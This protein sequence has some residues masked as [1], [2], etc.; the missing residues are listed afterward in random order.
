MAGLLALTL[1]PTMVLAWL[2]Y[3][4][5]VR[6]EQD[7][8]VNH[9]ATIALARD[10]LSAEL[11]ALDSRIPRALPAEV[12]ST[13]LPAIQGWLSGVAAANPWTSDL[14]FV[15]DSNAIVTR[16]LRYGWQSAGVDDAAPSQAIRFAEEAEFVTRDL[17]MA[18]ERYRTAYSAASDDAAKCLAQARIGRTLFKLGRLA[19]AVA[20]YRQLHAIAG[21]T[22]S[23]RGV[24]YAIIALEE[25]VDGLDRGSTVQERRRTVLELVTTIINAPWDGSAGYAYHLKRAIA[26]TPSLDEPL[27]SQALTRLGEARAIEALAVTG[28]AENRGVRYRV[29]SEFVEK[30][31]LPTDTTAVAVNPDV[32]VV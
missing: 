10:K 20:A 30:H 13:D 26:L 1:V 16:A 14:H 23:P 22:R 28:A 6:R 3:R 19:E 8:R 25:I 17:P 4:D 18:V 24:P 31:L 12:A 15:S 5:L 29:S 9:A 21:A 32:K 2:G 11:T 27:A 7:L